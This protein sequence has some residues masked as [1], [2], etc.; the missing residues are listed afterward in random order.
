MMIV[1]M[2]TMIMMICL[3]INISHW[4]SQINI[5]LVCKQRRLLVALVQ[6]ACIVHKRLAGLVPRVASQ[7]RAH[8]HCKLVVSRQ[9]LLDALDQL[10]LVRRRQLWVLLDLRVAAGQLLQFDERALGF[11]DQ[12]LLHGVVDV[13]VVVLADET[14]RVEHHFVDQQDERVARKRQRERQREVVFVVTVFE[15][16]RQLGC[17]FGCHVVIVVVCNLRQHVQKCDCEEDA[18]TERICD[19]ENRHAVIFTT[20]LYSE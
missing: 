20:E 16:V 9:I 11:L 6:S 10:R 15:S 4:L 8:P 13:A 7:S 5:I 18:S 3:K 1:I 19:A 2:M 12:V 14:V 17:V